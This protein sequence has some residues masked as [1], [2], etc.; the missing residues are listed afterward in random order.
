MVD[1][2]TQTIVEVFSYTEEEQD[3]FPY[4]QEYMGKI[5]PIRMQL[6]ATEEGRRRYMLAGLFLSYRASVHIGGT[7]STSAAEDFPDSR[8]FCDFRMMTYKNLTGIDIDS[9]RGYLRSIG[10]NSLWKC[11][12]LLSVLS[13]GAFLARFVKG[14]VSRKR[15][16]IFC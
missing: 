12:L 1:E 7:M 4:L 15:K 9:Q 11:F 2:I 14:A 3:A 10:L 13:P 5:M 8:Y 16:W 6:L